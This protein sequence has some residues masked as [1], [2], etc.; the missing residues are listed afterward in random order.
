MNLSSLGAITEH[1]EY[2]CIIPCTEWILLYTWLCPCL[3]IGTQSSGSAVQ[4]FLLGD[5][6][7]KHQ[8]FKNSGVP[9]SIKSR[10]DWAVLLSS[11]LVVFS[12]KLSCI[13]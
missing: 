1:K 3:Y 8:R 10:F 9:N 5:A 4:F 11:D 13:V 6:M 2:P 12:S 7:S